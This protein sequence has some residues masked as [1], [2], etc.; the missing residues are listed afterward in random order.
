MRVPLTTATAAAAAVLLLASCGSGDGGDS[1]AAASGELSGEGTGDSCTI[2]AEVP[3]GAVLSLTGAAASYGESQQRG[4]ELAAAQLADKGG[5]TYDLRIEDDQTDPRQGITLFD[6]FVSDGVSLIIGP[7]LSNAAIQ[8]DPI[9]QE[10]GVPVLGISNTA[11]G[12]TEIGDYVF[13]NSLTEQAVIPQTIATATEEFGLQDVVVMYSNDDAFT[14]SG[15]EAFAA[16]LEDQGVTVSET[17]TFSKADTDFRALLTQ[18]QQSDPDALVVSALIEAAIP[19]VTQARELGIDVPIIGGNGFNNPRLMADAGQAAEG[20]VVG[21]AWNSASDNPENAAFLADFEAEYGAQPDQFAAQAYAGLMLVDQAV[22]ADCAAD[23]ESIKQALG[24]LENV[25]TV[26]GEFSIDENR[27]AVHPAVVQVVQNGAFA[28][29]VCAG[30]PLGPGVP[31]GGD[32]RYLPA[33][34]GAPGPRAGPRRAGVCRHDQTGTAVQQLLNG[35]FIGSI[36]ALFAIGFTL[37]FGILDRLNLAHPAVFAASAFVGI[38]LVERG[39]LSLWAALPVVFVFGAVLGLVIERLAFRPLKGRADAHFAGLI[40][41]IALAGMLIAL[42]QWRYG[43]DT[44]RFPAGS[45]P[46]TRFEVAGAQVTLAQVVILAV[47]LTLM[48][49]LTYMV[50]RTRLG[51][52]MRAVA[53]NPTAA[54][55]LGVDVDRI[56]A[57][58]FAISSALGAVAGVLFAI[59]VNTAQLGMGSAI[60]LKGLAVIIVGG[61]GSLPGALIGGLVLGLAEVFAVQ[62]IGSSWRDVI[63]FGLLFLILLV[64]PQGLLGARKVREV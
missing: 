42:L 1:G 48:V 5:V 9:A 46:E 23:R 51:R 52:G 39:G 6:Q 26:L 2:E 36:Y 27:D 64:R 13:R 62:Y 3:V 25:P 28:V 16:A 60:E 29:L 57:V 49:G 17:I 11:A 47:S 32:P 33:G 44:R 40:S 35:I 43:P 31:A 4:L 15:Y 61:M 53:E 59:N 8:A 24:E 56:T 38:E 22:R 50:T 54:R 7:T 14:E 41:S 18:A 20:V 30:G 12:V 37:V 21:A 63:A 45:F 10:A 19:L 34:P 58:T 55:V